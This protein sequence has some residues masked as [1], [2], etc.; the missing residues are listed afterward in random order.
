MSDPS[1]PTEEFR[2][3]LARATVA[4]I[5]SRRRVAFLRGVLLG[6]LL[7]VLVL[8]GAIVLLGGGHL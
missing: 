7:G 5:K 3:L 2:L 1:E 6:Y 4:L 8:S